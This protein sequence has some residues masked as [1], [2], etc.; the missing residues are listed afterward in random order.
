M[1]RSRASPPGN[2]DRYGGGVLSAV[3]LAKVGAAFHRVAWTSEFIDASLHLAGAKHMSGHA[4]HGAVKHARDRR[5]TAAK[6]LGW[7]T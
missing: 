4:K 3:T 1:D 5:R 7:L 6:R 2:A